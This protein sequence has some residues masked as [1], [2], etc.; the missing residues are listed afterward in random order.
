MQ[1]LM[2]RRIF[3]KGLCKTC[4]KPFEKKAPNQTH[5]NEHSFWRKYEGGSI[6]GKLYAIEGA[7]KQAADESGNP[8]I[9]RAGE[10][11]QDFLKSLIPSRQ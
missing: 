1:V 3:G 2:S 4:K 9:W 5:C 10:C 11:S 8:R 7:L 6:L